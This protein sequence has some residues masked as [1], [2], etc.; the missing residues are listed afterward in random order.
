MTKSLDNSDREVI[1]RVLTGAADGRIRVWELGTCLGEV[2]VRAGASSV[3]AYPAHETA[4]NCLT[5]DERNRFLLS[6]DAAGEIVVWKREKGWYEMLRKFRKEGPSAG[7]G[8]AAVAVQNA[9]KDVCSCGGVFSLVFHPDKLRAQML[10]LTENPAAMRVYNMS[11]YRMQSMCS[12][13]VGQG[14][15][16][17]GARATGGGAP[18]FRAQ[19]S[20]DGRYAIAGSPISTLGTGLGA[21]GAPHTFG[22]RVW[23][24]QTGFQINTPLSGVTRLFLV[25]LALLRFSTL[26]GEANVK[27]VHWRCPV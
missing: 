21:G 11:N 17:A 24:T 2:C 8:A 15:G 4:V 19:I 7:L 25:T 22:V 10:V 16:A 23:D 13:F 27:S 5:V 12:G 18:F 6:G 1:P 14:A 26:V 3:T 20:A 9:T